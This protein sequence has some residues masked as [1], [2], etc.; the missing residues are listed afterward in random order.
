V[1]EHLTKEKLH[2]HAKRDQSE[3]KE[4]PL[5]P[6]M[7][8]V[9]NEDYAGSGYDRGHMV[10]AGNNKSSLQGL[11][12]SSFCLDFFWS[13]GLTLFLVLLGGCSHE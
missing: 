3:F 4:D 9:S 7:F 12:S 11:G 10:P 5:I 8:R 1:A 13:S 2:G 6:Q